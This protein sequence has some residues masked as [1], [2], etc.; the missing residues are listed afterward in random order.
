MHQTK[1]FAI[2]DKKITLSS[3]YTSIIQNVSC[4][5]LSIYTGIGIDFKAEQ[6]D[7]LE[8]TGEMC[9]LVNITIMNDTIYETNE[10]FIIIAT[11]YGSD[12][13]N[14]IENRSSAITT[15]TVVDDDSKSKLQQDG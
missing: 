6:N 8:L 2:I 14:S 9:G 13:L 3:R 7:T 5:I 1:I 4:I 15:V 11:T 12:S 10:T